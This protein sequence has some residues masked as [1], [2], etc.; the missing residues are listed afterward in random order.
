MDFKVETFTNPIPQALLTPKDFAY[1]SGGTAGGG[2]TNAELVAALT[3]LGNGFG[4]A[5]AAE[6]EHE[7]DRLIVHLKSID[8]NLASILTTLVRIEANTTLLQTS[9][10]HGSVEVHVV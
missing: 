2:V 3:A 7:V 1:P 5:Q 6:I 10:L 4:N 8:G 9:N